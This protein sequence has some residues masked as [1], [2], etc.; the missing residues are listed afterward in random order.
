MRES[1]LAAALP[2]ARRAKAFILAGGRRLNPLRLL[3]GRL[4]AYRD[5]WR[6]RN[7]AEQMVG[8][9]ER[10]LQHPEDVPPYRSFRKL[11]DVLVSDPDLPRPARFLDIGCGAGAY[12]ELLERWAPGRFDYVGADFADEIVEAARARW[13][14]RTFVTCDLFDEGALDGYDVVF[15]SAL[16]DILSDYADALA[17]LCSAE[18]RWVVLHRQRISRRP[19][20][21]IA[22]GYSGQRT[23]RS[24][25]TR[26]L[27]D[28]VAAARG[29]RVVASVPVEA[30][31]HSFL[32]VRD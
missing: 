5:S 6:S 19:R 3:P 4:S 26:Q 17:T 21:E 7:V 18:A 14:D 31:V 23:Y 2:F 9:T 16:V 28:E 13:P 10:E 32:L 24:Y 27:L 15:A 1:P 30:D 8:L 20:A 12:G 29:R 22:R 11:L 25:V